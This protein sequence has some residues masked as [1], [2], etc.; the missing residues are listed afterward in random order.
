MLTELAS[1]AA[2]LAEGARYVARRRGPAAALGATGGFSLVFGP[3]FL[4]SVLLYRNYFYR[5]SVSVAEGRFG[6]SWSWPG[7][8]TPAR[9][10][11][12]RRPPGG[13]PSRPGSR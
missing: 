10:W 6:R 11:S 9:R 1:V 8:A 5:S 4:M 3:L 13:W 12:P 7:S 2:G